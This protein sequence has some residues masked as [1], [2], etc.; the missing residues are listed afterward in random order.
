MSDFVKK[1][2]NQVLRGIIEN[3]QNLLNSRIVGEY[4]LSEK[5]AKFILELV[6]SRSE[7]LLELIPT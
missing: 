5:R 7:R 4:R 3:I 1:Y 2:N 6:N